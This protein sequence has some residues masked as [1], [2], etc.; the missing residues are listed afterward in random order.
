MLLSPESEKMLNEYLPLVD[1]RVPA[2][3]IQLKYVQSD[4]LL[5]NLP[6]S[7][8]KDDILQTGDATLVFFTGS[9]DKLKQLRRE[10]ELLDRPAPQIRY[11][12]LVVQ[13]Q[14]GEG[15]DWKLKL[16]ADATPST[17][18]MS[19]LGGID[20]L[21]NL[22]FNIVSTFGYLFALELNL[23]LTTN[24]A[25]VLADTSLTGLSGQEIKFQNTETS[26]YQEFEID[27]DTGKQLATGVTREITT[28]LI[29][30]MN[31]WVSGDGMITMKVTSTVSKQGTSTSTGAG[32]LPTTSEKIVSTNVRTPSGKPVVIGGLIQQSK[33]SNVQKVPLLGDIPLLGFLFQTRSDTNSNT[34]LVIYIVPHLEYPESRKADASRQMEDLYNDFVKGAAG[35]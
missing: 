23:G 15:F 34:E 6:P 30:G 8:S 17:L 31:G 27:P 26:R 35:G 20:K 11:E 2:H 3:P 1:R 10:L 19:F 7:V 33:D 4:F 29:I 9:E 28:G 21:L 16:K 32:A 14:D 22:N 5:K 12:L 24:K 25:N 13:Y 18:P